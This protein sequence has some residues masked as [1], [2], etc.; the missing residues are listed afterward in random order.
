MAATTES[1]SP[2]MKNRYLRLARK[3]DRKRRRFLA[4]EADRRRERKT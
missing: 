2:A 1:M 3:G 4:A